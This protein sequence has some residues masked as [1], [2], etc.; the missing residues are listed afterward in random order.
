MI[1]ASRRMVPSGDMVAVD[2][3]CG[4]LMEKLDEVFN[5]GRRLRR[6][7][8]YAHQLGLGEPDLANAKS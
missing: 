5:K 4:S 3:Y 1:V 2:S 8:D 7:L 6:Q